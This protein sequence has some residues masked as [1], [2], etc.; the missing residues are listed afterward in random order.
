MYNNNIP[1]GF[2]D[3]WLDEL[4][5]EETCPKCGEY[6]SPQREMCDSCYFVRKKK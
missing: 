4:S 3:Q 2:D 1:A 6:K 5:T